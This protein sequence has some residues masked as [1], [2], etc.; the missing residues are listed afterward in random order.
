MLRRLKYVAYTFANAADITTVMS[1]LDTIARDTDLR[2]F[3]VTARA[4]PSF[5]LRIKRFM[6]PGVPARLQSSIRTEYQNLG[7]AAVWSIAK[8][9]PPP[10]TMSEIM[11]RTQPVGRDRRIFDLLIDFGQR[12]GYCCASNL[13]WMVSYIADH[14]LKGAELSA[15]VRIA[16]DTASTMATNRMRDLTGFAVP[17][18][19]IA[20]SPREK[21]TLQHLSDGL[22]AGEIAERLKLTEATVRTFILRGGKK[23]GAVNQ[24]HAVS[25]AIRRGLI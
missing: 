20:L 22:T 4:E 11:R 8:N 15:E 12:D 17:E 5:D 24:L 18:P 2:L 6:A 25:I 10:I 14:V 21:T 7:H 9:A 13:P 19:P 16:L 3:T 23:L 1:A